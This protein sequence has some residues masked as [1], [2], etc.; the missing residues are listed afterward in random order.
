[1]SQSNPIGWARRRA[2]IGL[3]L[4]L[5]YLREKNK[6]I[7]DPNMAKN[8]ERVHIRGVLML[9]LDGSQEIAILSSTRLSS[10][11]GWIPR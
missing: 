6:L 8:S 5:G 4:T 7:E 2:I 1:M 11:D 9:A 10:N 3:M